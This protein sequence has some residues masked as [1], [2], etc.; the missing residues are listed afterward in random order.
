MVQVLPPMVQ[1][2]SANDAQ[3][4][5]VWVSPE[6][7]VACRAQKQ[8]ALLNKLSKLGAAGVRLDAVKHIAQVLFSAPMSLCLPEA[9]AM[10]VTFSL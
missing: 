9:P 5:P 2:L 3:P 8:A 1:S 4:C 6:H 7:A 10:E